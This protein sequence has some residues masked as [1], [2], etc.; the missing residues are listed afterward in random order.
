MATATLRLKDASDAV[1]THDLLIENLEN[2][3]SQLPLFG[4]FCCRMAVQPDCQAVERISG[5]LKVKEATVR[6]HKIESTYWASLRN[7]QLRL[8]SKRYDRNSS[9]SFSTTRKRLENIEPDLVIPINKKTKVNSGSNAL[10]IT[11]DDKCFI[12]TNDCTELVDIKVWAKQLELAITDFLVWEAVA[13]Y[14]MPIPSPSPSRAPMYIKPRT[15]G[16]L[17]DETP[18]QGTQAISY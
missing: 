16:S 10:T 2:R 1:K 11:T 8:W 3:N 14:H 15:P 13:E 7:F 9:T 12:L 18:I 5:Y 6:A 4:H 17:Y